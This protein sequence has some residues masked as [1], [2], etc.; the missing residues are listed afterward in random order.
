VTNY[1]P[2]LESHDSKEGFVKSSERSLGRFFAYLAVV[3]FVVGLVGHFLIVAMGADL[4][5]MLFLPASA[6]TAL[7]FGFLGRDFLP[8]KIA[9]G[10]VCALAIL[11]ALTCGLFVLL[12]KSA[13]N[14][15]G[16]VQILGSVASVVLPTPKN[17]P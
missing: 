16:Q 15:H 8:G 9:I 14:G 4:P 12:T 13:Q 2:S 7:L 17:C 6:L 10:G 5:F 11:L 1:L 3:L